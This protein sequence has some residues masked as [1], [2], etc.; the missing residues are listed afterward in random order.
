MFAW[1]LQIKLISLVTAIFAIWSVYL[2]VSI[3]HFRT[4][5]HQLLLL[6]MLRLWKI[7]NK[8]KRFWMHL[9][10]IELY[11]DFYA[12]DYWMLTNTC[13]DIQ[14]ETNF[15]TTKINDTKRER[16]RIHIQIDI[17]KEIKLSVFACFICIHLRPGFLCPLYHTKHVY[18]SSS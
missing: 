18:I 15:E 11:R 4:E 10:C 8:I 14:I 6:N 17:D 9:K 3:V 13:T 1:F 12:I 16:E 5:T 2:W 7:K